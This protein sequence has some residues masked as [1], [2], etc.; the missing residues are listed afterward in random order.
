MV[1]WW[2][3]VAFANCLKPSGRCVVETKSIIECSAEEEER[4]SLHAPSEGSDAELAFEEEC[5]EDPAAPGPS[6]AC[7]SAC[8][9]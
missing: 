8:Q 2:S 3:S 4:G 6:R 5:A 7:T 9:C 1:Y